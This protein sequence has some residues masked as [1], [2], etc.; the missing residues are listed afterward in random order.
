[1]QLSLDGL[2]YRQSQESNEASKKRMRKWN[3]SWK[4][5]KLT[6]RNRNTAGTTLQ[7]RLLTQVLQFGTRTLILLRRKITRGMFHQLRGVTICDTVEYNITELRGDHSNRTIQQYICCVSC[8][9]EIH[10]KQKTNWLL[11][12]SRGYWCWLWLCRLAQIN[13]RWKT[14][15]KS[16][17]GSLCIEWRC[18]YGKFSI[19]ICGRETIFFLVKDNSTTTNRY[20]K[21]LMIRP[22]LDH[23]K[24]ST[25]FIKRFSFDVNLSQSTEWQLRIQCIQINGFGKKKDKWW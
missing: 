7:W 11:L 4:F 9:Y 21:H 2:P 15:Y 19:M 10:I 16:S 12:G 5:L 6:F 24:A 22:S 3:R 13:V 8:M 17:I 25:I 18:Y 20:T 1:M 23:M 14:F